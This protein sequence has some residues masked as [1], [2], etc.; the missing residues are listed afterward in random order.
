MP[1]CFRYP[2]FDNRAL[3]NE[4]GQYTYD[5]LLKT[6]SRALLCPASKSLLDV[7]IAW[8]T[9]AFVHH[10]WFVIERPLERHRV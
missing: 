1:I 8:L 10:Y 5:Y 7:Q 4:W 2:G 3:A 9:V 6:E